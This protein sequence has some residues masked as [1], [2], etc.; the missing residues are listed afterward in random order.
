[1]NLI[2]RGGHLAPLGQGGSTTSR[3]SLVRC[4]FVLSIVM[5]LA[6]TLLPSEPG[7]EVHWNQVFCV[8]C[9]QG[10]LADG[11]ANILL[12]LPLG[13]ALGW[14][15][16]APLGALL[17]AATLSLSVELAQFAV[18]G[19][20]PNLGDFSFNTLGAALGGGLLRSARRWAS[21]GPRVAS[22]LSLVAA[23]VAGTV[24]GLTDVLFRASLPHTTYFGG[25]R[26]LQ[27]SSSP[28]RLGGNTD[29]REYF[30]GRIDE[31][32]IYSRAQTPAEIQAD[33]NMPVTAASTSPDLVAAYSFDEGS[34]TALTDV[35]GHGNTGR[36]LGATWTN[37]GKFGGALVFDGTGSVVVV[38]HTPSLNLTASMTLEAW[39]YP[40]SVQAG[41]RAILQKEFDAYFLSASSKA[42]AL[43]PGGGGTFGSSTEKVI[44]SSAVPINA[45][46]HL[47]LTYDGAMLQLYI[48]GH[49]A[50]RRLRW[51]P[52]RVLDASLDGL[53]ISA[54]ASAESGELRERLL[55]GVPLRVHAVAG[56]P[57]PAQAPLVTLHD[58][59]RHEILLLGA[60][61][62]DL[63]FR[64]RTR[65]AAAE[66]DTPAIRARGVMRGLTSGDNLV[67]TISRVGRGHCVD[68]NINSTCG[69]GFTLG[70]GWTLFLYSQ[71][72]TGWPHLALNA[73]W[74]AALS[75]PTG[76]WARC[77]WESFLGALVLTVGVV[78]PC[79]MGSLTTSPMEIAAAVI[80]IL[81]GLASARGA[82]STKL[83]PD[84][85][86]AGQ[87]GE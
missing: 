61:K 31:V 10:S 37:Q 46:T 65:A 60:E 28:L 58:R 80:G 52:G 15:G 69:L 86:T 70:M 40:S 14:Q 57:V 17:F 36:I 5:V 72:P 1:M 39:I 20:D 19:R 77:R 22:R 53:A 84:S 44:A 50:A 8:L 66:L 7:D 2:A 51:Y 21:P 25:S 43:K 82:A 55:S 18:P 13:I 12:F 33:M 76:F 64:F 81:A 56:P 79:T 30:Q 26:L 68:V 42:G 45:W 27:T 75:F 16:Y 34:G 48:N 59:F 24:F 23:L 11:F 47:A 54:G 85:T 49:P 67:V 63:V 35:S 74:M 32:R 71:I 87:R 83:H 29:S 62:D 38:P 4:F 78:L 3:P 41:R 9:G 6:A 73:L